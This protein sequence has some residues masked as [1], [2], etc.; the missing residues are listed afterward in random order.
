MRA[1]IRE[2][3]R[4]TEANETPEQLLELAG[5]DALLNYQAGQELLQAD[6]NLQAKE[7]LRRACDLDALRLRASSEVNQIIRLLAERSGSV[8]ADIERLLEDLSPQGIIGILSCWS[9]CILFW[10]GMR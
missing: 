9:M 5:D 1:R 6:R 10:K 2:L 7:F 4:A 3:A 8:Y